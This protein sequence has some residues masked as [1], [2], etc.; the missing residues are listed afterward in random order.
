[1]F[2]GDRRTCGTIDV[3]PATAHHIL[4]HIE[5]GIAFGGDD[6]SDGF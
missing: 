1:M 3:Q 4:T 5:Q 2:E 6:D